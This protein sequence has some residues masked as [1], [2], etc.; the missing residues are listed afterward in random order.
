MAQRVEL[1]ACGFPVVGGLIGFVANSNGRFEEI[2][3]VRFAFAKRF[4]VMDE[5]FLCLL[6]FAMQ[7]K[8]A[9]AGF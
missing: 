9:I 5:G 4:E 8:Q 7:T 3:F 6:L 1:A 2:V